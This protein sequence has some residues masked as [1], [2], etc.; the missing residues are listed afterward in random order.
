MAI[1]KPP[2]LTPYLDWLLVPKAG[3]PP[4]I[5]SR[6]VLNRA[7]VQDLNLSSDWFYGRSFPLWSAGKTR[8]LGRQTRERDSVQQ[9][10]IGSIPYPE[11][12]YRNLELIGC[13]TKE[14][15]T[16]G[17]FS[18]KSAV[19]ET[20]ASEFCHSLGIPTARVLSVI[21]DNSVNPQLERCALLTRVVRSPLTQADLIY[22]AQ[23]MG[24]D[25]LHQLLAYLTD[26]L[27]N[28]TTEGD[29]KEAR[30]RL[31]MAISNAALK[32][33]ASWEAAGFYYGPLDHESLTVLAETRGF[34]QCGF[35][36]TLGG[37]F[38]GL[39]GQTVEG[40]A[41]DDQRHRVIALCNEFL[42]ILYNRMGL[43]PLENGEQLLAKRY[44]RFLTEAMV[45]KLG[46]AK[47]PESA[48][49]VDPL[50]ALL[51][52]Y[53]VNYFDFFFSL[54]IS[55]NQHYLTDKFNR[56]PLF[57]QW[58]QQYRL[59][60]TAVEYVSA[61]ADEHRINP[62]KPLDASKIRDILSSMAEGNRNAVE[63]VLESI[64]HRKHLSP[65][66]WAS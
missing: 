22:V 54:N 64:Y 46:M 62:P 25:Y 28:I 51:R 14:T 2:T 59:Q 45:A 38:P 3:I 27:F 60:K 44:Q 36:N 24:D 12:G 34:S 32:T 15:A 37:D 21:S 30:A 47:G 50:L 23:N 40:K 48:A 33:A 17:C 11:G 58:L 26:N 20:V 6:L 31:L 4:A 35:I 65:T 61:D 49:L 56:D 52:K 8:G 39:E 29:D 66:Q 42:Q 13:P 7:L 53:A 19:I 9:L 43:A 55:E 41:F 1:L 5:P 18:T 57:H 16:R 10:L 63:N